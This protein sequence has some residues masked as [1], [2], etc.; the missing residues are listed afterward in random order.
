MANRKIRN[1]ARGLL[2]SA[3]SYQSTRRQIVWIASSTLIVSV[4]GFFAVLLWSLFSENE[5]LDFQGAAGVATIIPAFAG[6]IL[7]A[8]AIYSQIRAGSPSYRA[9]EKNWLDLSELYQRAL[10]LGALLTTINTNEP[11]VN[12]TL[13]VDAEALL[14]SAPLST[15]A[16]SRRLA[17]R[18][19]EKRCADEFKVDS[20][21]DSETRRTVATLALEVFP[22]L[23][24]LQQALEASQRIDLVRLESE[25]DVVCVSYDPGA[26][27][28]EHAA[29]VAHALATLGKIVDLIE[30]LSEK[31]LLRFETIEAAL[32]Q[33]IHSHVV[34]GW[35]DDQRKME[36]IRASRRERFGALVNR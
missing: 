9:A 2:S 34:K 7:A 20:G 28:A 21:T 23:D 27:Y 14:E 36:K 12:S 32:L 13:D 11:E 18:F 16:E 17:E 26:D 35:F 22:V 25:L 15:H 29:W 31:E 4:V 6:V 10:K 19:S 1:R 3:D 8:W 33:P 24:S 30:R 5:R